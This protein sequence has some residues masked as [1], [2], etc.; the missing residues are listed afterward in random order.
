MYDVVVVGG[1]V[2]GARTA[3]LLA[4]R[5]A[6]VLLID[7]RKEISNP[8]QCTGFVSHRF[9]QILP[10]FPE[11][12]QYNKVSK[13]KFFSPKK[14]TFTL[15]AK[16]F[17]VIDR[18]KLDDYLLE[19]AKKAGVKVKTGVIFNTKRLR[20]DHIIADTDSGPIKTKL[21]I[22]ADGPGSAV[23]NSCGIKAKPQFYGMQATVRGDFDPDHAEV[24]FGSKVAPKY[25][26]WLVP[27]SKKRARIGL[28]SKHNTYRYYKAFTKEKLG[29]VPKPDVT[30]AIKCS[31]QNQ[32]VDDRVLLIGDAA[33]QVKPF[34]GGGIT[35]SLIAANIC[36]HAASVALETN[37]FDKK[38]LK[39][40]YQNKA[41][42]KLR[43]PIIRGLILHKIWQSLPD[44]LMNAAFS[45]LMTS[46]LY[47]L[48]ERLDVDFY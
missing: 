47:K 16:P 38:F 18:G 7:S 14:Q 21:I 8:V 12:L 27:I 15:N 22:G 45:F 33:A 19:R 40:V 6:D 11:K 5:G 23:A 13:A 43:M 28:A 30:G 31:Y 39:K 44:P 42:R 29:K 36:A 46:R 1:R 9:L 35:Y 3:E 41:H 17:S 4:K 2:A 37:K 34:S 48:V 10:S 20:D 25:F 26:A 24:H 32:I